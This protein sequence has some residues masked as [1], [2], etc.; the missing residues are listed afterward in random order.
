MARPYAPGPKR[1]VFTAEAAGQSVVLMPRAGVIS[2]IRQG[3]QPWSEHLRTGRANRCLPGAHRATPRRRV[4]QVVVSSGCRVGRA[5]PWARSGRV[6]PLP[7]RG[8]SER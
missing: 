4:R 5:T 1:F 7:V 2:R 6:R 3:D 8:R